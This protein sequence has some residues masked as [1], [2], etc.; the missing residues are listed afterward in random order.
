MAAAPGSEY[1]RGDAS[2]P[3]D[4]A[5]TSGWLPEYQPRPSAAA[6]AAG[7]ADPGSSGLLRLVVILA[8]VAIIAIVAVWF[9]VLRGP[10]TTG[11]EFL[12]TWT[13]TTQQGIGT[14]VVERTGGDAFLVTLSGS[15]EAEKVAVPAHLD[16]AEL[17]I[18]MDDFSQIAGEGNAERFKDALKALAGDFRIVFT[19]VDA[20][21]LDLR[22]TGTS[23]SG[24]DFDQTIPLAQEPA[25]TT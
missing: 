9:F 20:T 19:S 5:A 22:I 4:P 17:V 15:K 18:T 24:Q 3:P 13:A 14:A 23:A 6:A 2:A 11:E 12:G 7:P 16:G 1:D 25:G 8:V 10:G 21:H